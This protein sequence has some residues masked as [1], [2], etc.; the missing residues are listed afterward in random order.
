[1]VPFVAP[2]ARVVGGNVAPPAE[3]IAS[4]NRGTRNRFN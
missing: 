4:K 1:M 2:G 3:K